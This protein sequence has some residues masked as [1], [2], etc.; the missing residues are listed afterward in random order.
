MRKI[1]LFDP[2]AFLAQAGL[3]RMIL[4]LKKKQ[5]VFS[6]GDPAEDVFYIQHGKVRLSVISPGGKEATIAL[7]GDGDFLGEECIASSQ[8]AAHGHGDSY[9]RERGAQD[10]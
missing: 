1:R 7:L 2:S 9:C 8:A 4:P 5:T 3:G 10:R 6:Q